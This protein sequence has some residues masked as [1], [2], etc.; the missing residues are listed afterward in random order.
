MSLTLPF[1]I[2]MSTLAALSEYSDIVVTGIRFIIDTLSE[3]RVTEGKAAE[4][5]GIDSHVGGY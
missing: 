2:L 4:E 5:N 3:K 1:Y